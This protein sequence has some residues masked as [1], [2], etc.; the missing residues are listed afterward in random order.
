MVGDDS[1][2]GQMAGGSAM[3]GVASGGRSEQK[4]LWGVGQL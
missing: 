1:P 4:S 3:L 2:S